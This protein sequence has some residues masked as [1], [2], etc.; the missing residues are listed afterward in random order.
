MYI[1]FLRNNFFLR[2]FL[3]F[4]FIFT[5]IGSY[6]FFSYIFADTVDCSMYPASYEG[7][8]IEGDPYLVATLQ[9]L[10]CMNM[11]L[12]AYYKLIADIDASD[13][14]IWYDGAGFMPIGS[15]ATPFRGAFDG[16]GHI[17]SNL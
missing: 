15:S 12:S 11:N 10:Q 3:A 17:I 2:A 13:T 5:I 4:L 6:S 9:D 7:S 1:M 14:A 8:G 16:A